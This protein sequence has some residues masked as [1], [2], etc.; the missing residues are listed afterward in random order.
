[1]GCDLSEGPSGKQKKVRINEK[2]L[3]NM[4]KR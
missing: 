3:S 2:E 4:W 1:M